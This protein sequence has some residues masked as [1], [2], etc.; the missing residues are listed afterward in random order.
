M[1]FT[2]QTPQRP[3]PGAYLQTPAPNKFQAGQ[4][5]LPPFRS[6]LAPLTQDGPQIQNQPLA[7]S[8]QQAP[9]EGGK[10]PVETLKPLDRAARTINEVLSLET[11][12]PELDSY[13]GR[14]LLPVTLHHGSSSQDHR[15]NFV[16]L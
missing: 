5:S 12:Y 8:T 13:I 2:V 6:N 16:R 15:G 14:K 7:S 9:P 4:I 11:K 1:A 3:L 10:P